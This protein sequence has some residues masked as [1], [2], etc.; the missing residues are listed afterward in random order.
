MGITTIGNLRQGARIYAGT[1]DIT[2][3][4]ERYQVQLSVYG[5]SK[6]SLN[7]IYDYD[8]VKLIEN[9]LEKAHAF[10][11]GNKIAIYVEHP[12]APGDYLQIFYG[13]VSGAA[14]SRS[15]YRA[16]TGI[17]ITCTGF[18][19]HLPKIQ[20]PY[21]ISSASKNVEN[22]LFLIQTG[23]DPNKVTPEVLKM[24]ASSEELS[25]FIR[26]ILQG[27]TSRISDL[28]NIALMSVN[29]F[30]NVANLRS[31]QAI[32]DRFLYV[33]DAEFPS[34]LQKSL[35]QLL[36]NKLHLQNLGGFLKVAISYLLCEM[37]SDSN[38]SIVIKPPCWN[39]G[40]PKSHFIHP[41]LIQ[42]IHTNET[43]HLKYTRVLIRSNPTTVAATSGGENVFSYLFG[44]Y[45][46]DDTRV[47][48]DVK[49]D[50]PLQLG[51]I[52]SGRT[53]S[54]DA[55]SGGGDDPGV[56]KSTIQIAS[57]NFISG[58]LGIEDSNLGP[59]EYEKVY[60]ISVYAPQPF[61]HTLNDTAQRE[62]YVN[63]VL[64]PYAKYMLSSANKEAS[65]ASIQTGCVVPW[66]RVGFN[67]MPIPFNK[68]YYVAAISHTGTP[69]KGGATTIS[70]NYGSS[71]E[72]LKKANENKVHH[73]ATPDGFSSL[74][75]SSYTDDL[76]LEVPEECKRW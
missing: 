29:S 67:C 50:T 30:P 53:S 43:N 52:T 33:Q 42:S 59:S 14:I 17:S 15:K 58:K 28:V 68:V 74:T 16:E 6:A 3:L 64:Y 34:I 38:G 10:S 62:A 40:I 73:F 44:I 25:K 36:N 13:E 9:P 20:F 23:S 31:Y 55:H 11:Y 4:V 48:Y 19:H 39:F 32:K 2:H 71:L 5:D 46:E 65:T 61:I 45:K 56:G 37:F 26:N 1:T 47:A 27:S 24:Y 72:A 51:G 63:D 7:L 70:G 35:Q 12:F 41:M 18:L 66:L 57:D 60:G 21:G 69:G 22:L 8:I 75:M 76:L 49:G 54:R